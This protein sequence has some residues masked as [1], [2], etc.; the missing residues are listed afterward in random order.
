[1]SSTMQSVKQEARRATRPVRPWVEWLARF[2]YAAKGVVYIVMGILALQA[3]QG[4]SSPKVDQQAA[5]VKIITQPSGRLMLAVIAVGLAGYVLWRLIQTVLDPENVGSDLK[6][7]VKRSA[8]LISGAGYTVLILTSTQLLRGNGGSSSSQATKDFTAQVM[9]KPF[10]VWIVLLVGLF[11]IGGALMQLY[12]A[13]KG[14]F[15]E[16][17]K[18]GQMKGEEREWVPRLGRAGTAARAVV[19]LIVGSFIVQA[20]RTHNPSKAGGLGDA[21]QALAQQPYGAWLLGLV[22]LGLIAYGLYAFFTARYRV[23]YL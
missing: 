14:N 13:F 3:T 17:F 6:G 7:L 18:T 10:G 15:K 21:M 5:L 12:Q 23:I 1:M 16:R 11:V 20:A 8:Y 4:A 2:G 19:Y 22:A 9:S